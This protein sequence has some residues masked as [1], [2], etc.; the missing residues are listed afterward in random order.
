MSLIAETSRLRIYE[1]DNMVDADVEFVL[2]LYNGESFIKNIGDRNLRTREDAA[3]YM[4]SFML[5]SYK[6]NGFGPY[7]MMRKEEE[8]ET[9]V[10]MVGLLKREFT[11]PAVGYVVLG[12]FHRQGYAFAGAQAM[13]ELAGKRLGISELIGLTNP[14]NTASCGLLEKLGMKFEKL[15]EYHGECQLYRLKLQ[16]K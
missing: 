11:C 3:K 1:F 16:M 5:D 12:E 9:F 10:G 2:K 6:K 4:Q 13:V 7:K 8:G 14:Q 15:V